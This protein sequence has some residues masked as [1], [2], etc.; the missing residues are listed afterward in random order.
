MSEVSKAVAHRCCLAS[1]FSPFL[2][3]PAVSQ[4]LNKKIYIIQVIALLVML[5]QEGIQ[6]S[7]WQNVNY[8]NN[9]CAALLALKKGDLIQ[10]GTEFAVME[11]HAQVM[12]PLFYY[13]R[14]NWC[15]KVGNNLYSSS[16]VA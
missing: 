4:R 2:K 5:L 10:S 13:H 12:K 16:F 7:I 11:T 14:S 1:T 6:P 3:S 8:N 9:L 15:I